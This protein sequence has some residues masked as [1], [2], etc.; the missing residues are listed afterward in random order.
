MDEEN[1][2]PETD[3][4]RLNRAAVE[5]WE[6]FGAKSGAEP[7]RPKKTA[8]RSVIREPAPSPD[9]VPAGADETDPAVII[10]RRLVQNTDIMSEALA[11]AKATRQ[12]IADSDRQTKSLADGAANDVRNLVGVVSNMTVS[13][14]ELDRAKVHNVYWGAAGFVAGLII[15]AAG[16]ITWQHMF[17]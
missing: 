7:E 10:I 3:S 1:N 12:A 8:R 2:K 15:M 5:Y 17:G 11:E 4:D 14:A 6:S 16:V 13:R 9:P